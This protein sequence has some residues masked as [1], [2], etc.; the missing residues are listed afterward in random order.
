MVEEKSNLAHGFVER[1]L[2]VPSNDTPQE[3]FNQVSIIKGLS[4]TNS[5]MRIELMLRGYR[6]DPFKGVWVQSRK[7]VMNDIGIGNFMTALEGVGD[8][9][10]FSF[11]NEKDIPKLAYAFFADNFPHFLVYNNTFD[12]KP[13]DF[14]IIK[15]VLKFWALSVL[16]NSKNAGHR[17]VVR[18]TLSEG[19]LARALGN[20]P[21]EKKK[22]GLFSFL[23]RGKKE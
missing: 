11:T 21:E 19:I 16:S 10:N 23:K 15:T 1:T 13:E 8:N 2:A 22:G 17:N 14:N 12:L 7:P 9:V 18:G 5:T 6:F 20:A 3:T 4:T